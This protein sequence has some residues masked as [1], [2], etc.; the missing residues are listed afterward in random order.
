MSLRLIWRA[1]AQAD[2][3]DI[4]VFG[5]DRDAAFARD[6]NE[7]IR[8]C[9]EQLTHHPYG[10]PAGRVRG[11]REALVHPN[12]VLAYRAGEDAVEMLGVLHTCRQFPP[13]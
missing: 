3:R 2:L 8:H 1:M 11:T 10:H 12:Y 4:T 5:A 13:E 6:L 7:R 9:A